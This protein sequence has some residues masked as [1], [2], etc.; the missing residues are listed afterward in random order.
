[1]TRQCAAYEWTRRDR[2]VY[3][4]TLLPFLVA[5]IGAAILIATISV[6]WTILLLLI[7]VLGCFFQAGCCIGCP[8]RG[9]YCPAIFGIFLANRLSATIYSDR[10]PDP[11]FFNRNAVL[12]ASTVFVILVYCEFWLLTIHWGYAVLF[13]VLGAVH[14]ALFFRNI[15]PKCGYNETCPAGRIACRRG[16]SG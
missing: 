14:V 10:E 8:Y 11:E 9:R 2:L 4:S 7:Y 16:G 15:C 5:F 1:M 12:A 13:F 6:Y 3:F